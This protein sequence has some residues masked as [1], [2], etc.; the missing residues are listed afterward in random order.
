MRP[1]YRILLHSSI[2]VLER[3]VRDLMEEGWQPQGGL[4]VK[5]TYFYQAMAKYDKSDEMIT[6]P[7]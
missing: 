7:I 6:P 3:Q 4:A 2:G 5:D 1:Q